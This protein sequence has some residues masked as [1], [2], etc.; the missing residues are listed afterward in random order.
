MGVTPHAPFGSSLALTKCLVEIETYG[1]KMW[2]G[3]PTRD[4]KFMIGY[5]GGKY[6]YKRKRPLVRNG[7]NC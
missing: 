3:R 5:S 7:E 4:D 6:E 2:R 1:E